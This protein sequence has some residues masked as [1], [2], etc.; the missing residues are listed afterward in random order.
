[1]PKDDDDF[2]TPI[3][4]NDE[5]EVE[6]DDEDDD[7]EKSK[8]KD[9]DRARI[10]NSLKQARRERDDFKVELTRLRRE[11]AELKA[12][13][14]DGKD[15]SKDDAERDRDADERAFTRLRPTIVKAE[16][17]GALVQA[18]AKPDRVARLVR[19]LDVDEINVDE[20]GNVDEDDLQAEVERVKEEWPE[21]F[22]AADDEDEKP[23]RRA[24]GGRRDG[25]PKPGGKSTTPSSTAKLARML[26]GSK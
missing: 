6:T 9:D 2:D 26:T 16:A 20:K 12:G 15:S 14:S 8:L 1:M 21:L 10:R 11:V 4:D 19:L 17:K 7:G 25:A 23:R 5:R 3:D 13:K 18:G 24:A 22:K